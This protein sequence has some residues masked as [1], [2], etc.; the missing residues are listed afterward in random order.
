MKKLSISLL[1]MAAGV[2][3]TPVAFAGTLTIDH[4][5]ATYTLTSDITAD[6]GTV[7]LVNAYIENTSSAQELYITGFQ[8]YLG[9]SA[10][11]GAAGDSPS[12]FLSAG[13]GWTYSLGQGS[14]SESTGTGW[15]KNSG[16]NIGLAVDPKDS[17]RKNYLSS[18]ALI[19][20]S[21]TVNGPDGTLP[22]CYVGET[23][24][25]NTGSISASD[26]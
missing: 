14:Y 17:S 10:V 5:T 16:P 26:A 6:Q 9:G 20:G 13:N 18:A 11:P 23:L 8:Y 4:I 3:L 21:G 25:D 7:T 2:A 24:G 22:V 1:A 12:T 19:N 15:S